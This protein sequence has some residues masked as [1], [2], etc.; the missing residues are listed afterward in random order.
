MAVV[1]SF[2]SYRDIKSAEQRIIKN[3][4]AKLSLI[5]RMVKN[6]LMATMIEGRGTEFKQLIRSLYASDINS[7]ILF[8]PDGSLIVS[9]DPTDDAETISK[10]TDIPKDLKSPTIT[11]HEEEGHLVYA[12]SMP[13]FNERPCQKCHEGK[14]EVLSILRVEVVMDSLFESVRS[15]RENTLFSY[16]FTFMILL[17]AICFI[18]SRMVTEPLKG[19]VETVRK[20]EAGDLRARFVYD[21]KDEIGELARGLNSM[22]DELSNAWGEVER[23]HVES[24]QRVEKMASIGELAS[25]I[26]HEI[27]NPLAGISGAIQ[28][29]AEDFTEEDPRKGI[30]NEVLS[31]IDRLDKAVKDLLIFA[32]PPEAH[33]IRTSIVPVVERSIRYIEPIAKK[34]GVEVTFLHGDSELHET[35]VDP[36]QMQQVFLNIMINAVHSMPGGGKLMISSNFRSDDGHIVVSFSDTGEGI[37]PEELKNMFKPFF[38]TRHIGTGLG[39]AIGK[40]LAEKNDARMAVQSAL[41]IGTTIMVILPVVIKK[42]SDV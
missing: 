1:V 22:L 19:I 15:S 6:G 14:D 7:I 24:I 17:A 9:S 40:S 2:F 25:A 26:A 39:L 16:A 18:T 23:C 11:S 30:I 29:F 4:E 42:E 12:M 41:G 38:S 31:E 28:V 36:D 37:S 21:K 8:S 3:N 10:I 34:S 20:V 35:D 13:L 27:K 32:K 5:T 33:K